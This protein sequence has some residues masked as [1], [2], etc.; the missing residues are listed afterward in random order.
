MCSGAW[1]DT[2]RLRI[3]PHRR[4]GARPLAIVLSSLFVSTATRYLPL[5]VSPPPLIP[6]VL[7]Q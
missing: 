4:Y 5:V 2:Q 1:I 6:L 7:N 3:S